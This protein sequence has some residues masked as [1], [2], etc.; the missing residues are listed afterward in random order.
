MIYSKDEAEVALPF[1][2]EQPEGPLIS[3]TPRETSEK[4]Q[5]RSLWSAC[6]TH[7]RLIVRDV[8]GR[9]E[10]PCDVSGLLHM[11]R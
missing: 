11:Y 10:K 1:V 4:V 7:S 3:V 8:T 2:L 5:E 6:K 9:S